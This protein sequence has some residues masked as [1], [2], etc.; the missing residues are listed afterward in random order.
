MEWKQALNQF[1][2]LRGDRIR[3][4]LGMGFENG[5]ELT[6]GNHA[7][8]KLSGYEGF[9]IAIFLQKFPNVSTQAPLV[10]LILL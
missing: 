6:N 9:P 3:G 4:P 2:I 10:P 8:R 7:D 5:S 1:D